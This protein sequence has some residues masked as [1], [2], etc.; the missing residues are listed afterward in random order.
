MKIK[1]N[2]KCQ[3]C[4]TAIGL[5]L[6]K[7]IKPEEWTVDL[8]SPDRELIVTADVPAALILAAIEEAGFKGE[9]I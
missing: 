3:G 7:I 4:V 2:A 6:N 9:L 1:T 8:K 5:K